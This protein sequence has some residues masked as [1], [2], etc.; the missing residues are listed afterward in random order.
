MKLLDKILLWLG[1]VPK[2]EKDDMVK[3]IESLMSANADLKYECKDLIVKYKEACARI[4]DIEFET[5]ESVHQKNKEL[6]AEN[7][8]LHAAINESEEH[9]NA[10]Q[11][12]L[13]DMMHEHPVFGF[14]NSRAIPG[15]SIVTSVGIGDTTNHMSNMITGRTIFTDDVTAKINNAPSVHEKYSIAINKLIQL[16]ILDQIAKNMVASGSIQ[17]VLAF[18]GDCTASELYY[19]VETVKPDASFSIEYKK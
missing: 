12:Q 4:D 19:T 5:I 15:A 10:I 13:S 7:D 17:F 8:R 2:H 11:R 6:H 16:G 9:Y 3:H 14:G 1:Y 18:N